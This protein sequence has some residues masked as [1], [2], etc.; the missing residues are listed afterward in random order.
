MSIDQ[1]AH[2]PLATAR[3]GE[4]VRELRAHL[5]RLPT[6]SPDRS[7]VQLDLGRALFSQGRHSEAVRELQDLLATTGLAPDIHASAQA[8]IAGAFVLSDR[9]AEGRAAAEAALASPAADR[10]AQ[11]LARSAVRAL[12]LFDGRYE[13][14]VDQARVIVENAANGG[15][16]ARA[17]ARLDMGG[18]LF[19]ADR[20]AEAEEWLELD[21]DASA[22]HRQYAAET[23]A[24]LHLL[25]GRWHEVLERIDLHKL[26]G[27][28]DRPDLTRIY[29]PAFR[30]HALIHLDRIEQA[31]RELAASMMNVAPPI[32]LVAAGLLA[33]ADDDIPAMGAAAER[34]IAFCGE[35][36]FRPQL[37]S[38]GPDLVRLA[39][40]AGD[41]ASASRG[42]R[43]LEAATA[44]SGVG[45][46]SGAALLVR[47]MIDQDAAVLGRAIDAFAKSPRMVALAQSQEALGSVHSRAGED[48]PAVVA[49][50]AALV[51]WESMGAMRDARRVA[52]DLAGLGVHTRPQRRSGADLGWAAL[53]PTE[54]TV[55]G[56]IHEGL[57]NAQIAHRLV[58]SKRTVESHVAHV[59]TKLD[60]PSR[61]GV[62]RLAAERREN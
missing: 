18:M 24:L 59:L 35:P 19:H 12:S 55:A 38:W 47:G 30:A 9:P 32:S 60:V 48:G 15:P 26:G 10:E 31:R 13:D 50:R 62:A 53:S 33:E 1:F 21:A 36:R 42:A 34:G 58:I 43:E 49:L 11:V 45:S 46:V 3:P 6:D 52:R 22:N 4:T 40:R 2:H 8:V 51:T 25:S 41:V 28:P 17:E 7:G 57:S 20:F 39:L 5:D 37:R 23:R 29:R 16:V 54:Q 44:N 27:D 61:A 56:L 14:A